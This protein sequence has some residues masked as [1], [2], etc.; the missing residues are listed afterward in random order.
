MS[1]DIRLSLEGIGKRLGIWKYIW[2]FLLIVLFYAP[3]T[4]ALDVTLQWDANSETNI[5]GYKIYYDTDS[6][7]PYNGTGALLGNSPI[8]M[9]LGQDENSDPDVVEFTL[10]N[11]SNGEYYFAVTAYT[12]DDPS[13]ESA[14]S[15]EAK[16][17]P[18]QERPPEIT[19]TIPKDNSGITNNKRIPI[20]TSFAVL[21]DAFNGVNLTDATS[22]QFTID[23]GT[24][25]VY[26]RDLGDTSVVRVV[27]LTSDPDTSVTKF[28]IVYDRS[29][30]VY[31][32]FGYD[33]DVNIKV[34]A[35][36]RFDYIMTQAAFDFNIETTDEHDTA[37]A[38]RPETSVSTHA[39]ETT[40]TVINNDELNGFQ[41]VYDST[42][43][44]APFIEP[45]NEIPSLN[46]PDVT[47][48]DRPVE[49]GPPNVFS[50]PV[51]LIIPISGADDVRDL[52]VYLYDGSEWVY[53]VSSYNT[54]G[55]IQPGGEGWVVP[56][57]L[58]YH[59]SG[60]IPSL[61]IQVYHFSGIQT[62]LVS[63]SV[64]DSGS[65]GGCFIDAMSY[66]SSL[67]SPF[68]SN[69]TYGYLSLVI[70]LALF[71]IL[72][73]SFRQAQDKWC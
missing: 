47:P 22:V 37:Q 21:F 68:Y 10:N 64:A 56:G 18:P 58:T 48:V 29:L 17:T 4:L 44:I 5:A 38:N 6:G 63:V 59:D 73:A 70:V 2:P 42:E 9:P 20:D 72:W 35:K 36:D 23:D 12:N 43:P 52:G 7:A 14:Y 3:P 16:Y 41:I 15:N 69:K 24:N 13:L 40:I 46:L 51:K 33:V 19:R 61:E 32:N 60:P 30:D 53:A 31:G 54:G 27:K 26:E 45:L 67:G 71:V 50:H 11:L 62:G 49:L 39:G 65:G 8:D 55:I 25:A 66:G 1:I 57:T 28:W 34:D